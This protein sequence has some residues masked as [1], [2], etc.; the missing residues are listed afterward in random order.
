VNSHFNFS[1]GKGQHFNTQAATSDVSGTITISNPAT[2]GAVNFATAY[3]NAPSCVITP[4]TNQ[5][6]TILSY[7]VTT[8]TGSITANVQIAPSSAITF[9]YLCTGNPN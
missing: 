1:K 7:W 3:S 9:T 2:T 5:L 6:S 4:T 8:A